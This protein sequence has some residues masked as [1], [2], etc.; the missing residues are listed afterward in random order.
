MNGW[1]NGGW[2]DGYIPDGAELAMAA[3]GQWPYTDPER[4]AEAEA[5][6][7]QDEAAY[8]EAVVF[9]EAHGLEVLTAV[10]PDGSWVATVIF[11]GSRRT[12]TGGSEWE[13][14]LNLH[15][16]VWGQAEGEDR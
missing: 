11:Y 2:E 6:A 12:A 8:H 1:S 15:Q 10:Q 5:W 9:D 16:E 13:A 14:Y 4:E 7:A 3:E